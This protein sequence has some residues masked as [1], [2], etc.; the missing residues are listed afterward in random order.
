MEIIADETR[1]IPPVGHHIIRLSAAPD[2]CLHAKQDV[3]SCPFA[4][5][6]QMFNALL[7]R[8]RSKRR[9]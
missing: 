1:Q 9:S 5:C 4:Q 2:F 7:N 6:A 8:Q 3:N